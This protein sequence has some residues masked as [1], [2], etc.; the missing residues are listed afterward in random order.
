MVDNVVTLR[1]DYLKD[2]DEFRDSIDFNWYKVLEKFQMSPYL[3]PNHVNSFDDH[4]KLINPKLIILTGGG[5]VHINKLNKIEKNPRN[6]VEIKLL[7]FAIK[8]RICVIGVCRGQQLINLYFGGQITYIG[9]NG[10]HN[11]VEHVV[12]FYKDNQFY[13]KVYL[14]SFHNFIITPKGLSPKLKSV[15]IAEKDNSIE[16]FKH[17]NYRIYGISWHPE[18]GNKNNYQILRDF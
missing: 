3:L 9:E 17:V 11:S 16:A 2:R 18:R 4:I 1:H 10:G 12:Q 14:N 6:N 13:K 7:K 15:A 5:D 8:N